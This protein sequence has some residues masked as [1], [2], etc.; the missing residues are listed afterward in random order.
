MIAVSNSSALI[1]LGKLGY[2]GLLSD[3]FSKVLVPGAVF[4]EVS[5]GG[6]DELNLLRA[7]GFFE[8]FPV[9][10][11]YVDFVPQL[12]L[13]EAEAIILGLSHEPDYVIL[14]DLRARIIA[15]RSGLKVIGTLGL[16]RLFLDLGL[17]DDNPK[18]ICGALLKHG[19]WVH[20]DLCVQVLM[21]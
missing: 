10:G 19:F 1:I 16:L 13:G 5:V 17:I 2:L 7:N 18:S 9:S 8:V 14:D 3:V 4:D 21:S 20:N 15:Q 11:D 6:G 12:G